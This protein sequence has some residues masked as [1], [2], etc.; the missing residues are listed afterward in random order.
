M[1]FFCVLCFP[2]LLSGECQ[3]TQWRLFTSL[4]GF[5]VVLNRPVAEQANLTKISLPKCFKVVT[6]AVV[7]GYG[8]LMCSLH[9]TNLYS[10]TDASDIISVFVKQ[11]AT[12]RLI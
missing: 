3:L 2:R 6:H 12:E 4:F 8:G 5:Y 9:C 10:Q 7:K 1:V 11:A